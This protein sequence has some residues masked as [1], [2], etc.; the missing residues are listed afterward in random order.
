M[1]KTVIC[2]D[3]S[4]RSDLETP[5]LSIKALLLKHTRA[6]KNSAG[7]KLYNSKIGVPTR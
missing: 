6:S 2:I 4:L 7:E 5:T 3:L 1:L